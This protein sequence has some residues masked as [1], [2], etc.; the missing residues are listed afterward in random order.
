MSLRLAVVEV[1]TEP[2]DLLL[3]P[4]TTLLRP[5]STRN[6]AILIPSSPMFPYLA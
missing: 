2:E 5:Q 4:G 3:S 6:E 1:V